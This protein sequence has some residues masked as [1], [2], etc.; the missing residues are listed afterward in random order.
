MRDLPCLDDYNEACEGCLL[1]KQHKLPFSTNNAWRAKDLLELINT[2][3]CGPMR[4]SSLNN[5][6]YFIL[7]IDDFSRMTWTTSLQK[8]QRSLKYSRSSKLLLRN[9]VRNI[10]K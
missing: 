8:I 10:L 7:F 3:I 5:N 2:N 4:T 6:R 9:K 1:E